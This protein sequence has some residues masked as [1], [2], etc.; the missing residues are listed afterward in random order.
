[1]ASL[2]GLRGSVRP[3]QISPVAAHRFETAPNCINAQLAL[4]AKV[5]LD[6]EKLGRRAQE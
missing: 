2:P 4:Y 5:L 3:Y 6:L 1:M